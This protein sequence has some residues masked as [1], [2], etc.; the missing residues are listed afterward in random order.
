ME[1]V[2]E[3]QCSLVSFN[4]CSSEM[5]QSNEISEEKPLALAPIYEGDHFSYFSVSSRLFI[6]NIKVG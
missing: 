4:L 6:L 1:E 3:R 2:N 5:K